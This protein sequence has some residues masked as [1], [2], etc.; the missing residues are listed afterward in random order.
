[1]TILL[2]TA[3]NDEAYRVA[4]SLKARGLAYSMVF[5]EAFQL[6]RLRVGGS[7]FVGERDILDALPTIEDALN[8]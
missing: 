5:V 4:A 3:G 7:E 6:P 1:M 2:E 8:H